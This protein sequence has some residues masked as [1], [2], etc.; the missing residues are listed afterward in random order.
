MDDWGKFNETL[1]PGKEE[2]Y[3]NL[4]MKNITDAD[5]MH[6]K[7]ACKDFE[8]KNL[9]EYHN[10][11][12]KSDALLLVDIFENFRK[13]YLKVYH[14][15]S[16]KFLLA[17]WLAWSKKTEVK[18]ESLT[19][20]YMVLMVEKDIRGGICHAIYWY[21]KANNKFLKDYDKHEDK[22]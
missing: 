2:F 17:R 9:E 13:I 6:A 1:L 7:R 3:S 21:P 14:L 11:Y 10:F 18:L 5:Y 19:D 15:D 20:I 4:N 12:L 16:V 8:I 22:W